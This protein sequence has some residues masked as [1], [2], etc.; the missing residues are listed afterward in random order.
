MSSPR[1]LLTALALCGALAAG[2]PGAEEPDPEIAEAER[3]LKDARVGVDGA[4]L[5]KF[6][7]ERTLRETDLVKLKAK[8][9]QL[10]DESYEVREQAS[11][12]LTLAGR[13]AVP[14]LKAAVNDPDPEIVRRA[15][16]CLEDIA[17]SPDLTLAPAAARLLAVKKPDGTLAVLL[18]YLPWAGDENI[19]AAVIDALH[20]AGLK[21]GKADAVL[22]KALDDK[23]PLRRAAAAHV[24][25]QAGA[26]QNKLAA[27]L[28]KD[29][30]ARVRYRAAAALVRAANKE[31][32]PALIGLLG[33]APF[34]LA[35]QCEDLLFRIA[36]E[37]APGTTLVDN[38]DARRKAREVWQEWW[39]TKGDKV[40]LAKIKLDEVMR[41]LTL[42][43]NCDF[44]GKSGRVWE[45]RDGKTRWQFDSNMNCPSDAQA[46]PGGRVLI[47]EYQGQRVSE[48]DRDG[49]ILWEHKFG[50]F[51]TTCQ[52]L[53]NGNTFV[54]T[55]GE[56][57]EL[58]PKGAL[59]YSHKTT[60]AWGEIYRGQKLR[61]GHILFLCSQNKV[62]E[63]DAAGKEVRAIKIT[64]PAS[65]YGGVEQLANGRYLVNLYGGNKV[66]EIDADGKVHWEVSVTSPSSAQRLPNGHT[67]VSS[68]DARKVI[69]FDRDKKEV[70]SQKTEGRPFRVRRY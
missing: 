53:P 64:G 35:V 56:V 58:S 13:A 65:P 42:V 50:R 45:F 5:L 41:G 11:K 19:E 15:E 27:K 26:E 7:R 3:L 16:G 31:S 28:L 12:D 1:T 8:V 18:A 59:V 6:F 47:A 21:D 10:G 17:A 34:P 48:R 2:L 68:M 69:E 60:P 63:L 70:W 54:S 23:D 14:L 46:L 33:D 32:V 29:A 25:G 62:V 38:T 67:L 9:R 49:K 44:N 66:I 52:R 30:D 61:N 43:C 55:Y 51:V 36:G 22:V 20:R 40:D 57:A 39:K 37:Q 24:V 4:A